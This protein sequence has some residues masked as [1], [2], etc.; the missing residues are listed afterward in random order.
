M[1]RLRGS[2]KLKM[3][4][5]NE[6][7]DEANAFKNKALVER[8]RSLVLSNKPEINCSKPLP[9]KLNNANHVDSVKG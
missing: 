6:V 9:E 3:A 4:V 1:E 8:I 5:I 7:M 2:V